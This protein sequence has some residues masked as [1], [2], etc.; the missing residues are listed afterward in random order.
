MKEAES[1]SMIRHLSNIVKASQEGNWQAS[2]WILER[3]FPELWGRKDRFNLNSEEC[4]VIKIEKVEG[5][6]ED[7][8]DN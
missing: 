5:R 8:G 2:A 7:N 6:K 4:V 1:K 3:R